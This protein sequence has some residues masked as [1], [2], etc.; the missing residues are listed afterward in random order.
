MMLYTPQSLEKAANLTVGCISRII[1][2]VAFSLVFLLFA[3]CGYRAGEGNIL[4]NYRTISIPYVEGDWDGSLTACLV[5][6]V[7]QS[8]TVAYRRDGGSLILEAKL[9]DVDEEN[10]GF[11]YDRTTR[12]GKIK[13]ELIPIETRLI[14]VAEIRVIEAYS[15][16]VLLGPARVTASVD[17]D[18]DY[19]SSR[20]GINVFSLGQVTD[21]EEAE[22]AAQQP[23]NQRLARK[24][25][26]Y[27]NNSW[28][29]TP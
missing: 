25:T 27:I 2:R 11:R 16:R 14:A 5:K 24:I 28:S 18:H 10:I 19:F 1:C 4:S 3:G 6:E 23:L 8:S 21:I 15:G 22:D 26:D 29:T 13:H 7:S 9:I 12:R 17:F 20:N